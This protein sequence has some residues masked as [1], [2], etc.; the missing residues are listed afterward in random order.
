MTFQHLQK[1]AKDRGMVLDHHENAFGY[2][3]TRSHQEWHGTLSTMEYIITRCH[4]N[5]MFEDK[6]TFMGMPIE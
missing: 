2:R 6:T 5:T 3:L 1:L 4:D